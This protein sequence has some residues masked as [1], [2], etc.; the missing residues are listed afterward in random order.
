MVSCNTFANSY[1]PLST[2]FLG[3][4]SLSKSGEIKATN[5]LSYTPLVITKR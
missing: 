4:S 5:V 1:L 3:V 2:S